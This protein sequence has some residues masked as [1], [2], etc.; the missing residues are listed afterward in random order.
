MS[1][2]SSVTVY[3]SHLV[4]IWIIICLNDVCVI[5]TVKIYSPYTDIITVV[6][7]ME[8]TS[9][10]V[11]MQDIFCRTSGRS[12]LFYVH[13]FCF[14]AVIA[15]R[16]NTCGE[17]VVSRSSGVWSSAQVVMHRWQCRGSPGWFWC[18]SDHHVLFCF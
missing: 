3:R 14:F 15:M 8:A 17:L 16:C 18:C 11:N 4:F 12:D 7:Y 10:L 9:S 2:L 1:F 13:I 6:V 5:D